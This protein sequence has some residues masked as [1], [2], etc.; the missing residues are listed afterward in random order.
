V[1]AEQAREIRAELA[2]LRHRLVATAQAHE[3]GRAREW[4]VTHHDGGT[5]GCVVVPNLGVVA[6]RLS[7]IPGATSDRDLLFSEWPDP[8]RKVRVVS[9]YKREPR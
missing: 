7:L 4:A 9:A 3:G 6:F 5:Y 2:R 8:A 1:G